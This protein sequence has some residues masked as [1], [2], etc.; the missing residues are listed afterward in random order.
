[1][2]FQRI[3]V[4]SCLLLCLVNIANFFH[5][6]PCQDRNTTSAMAVGRRCRK[7]CR[8]GDTRCKGAKVCR[9]DH[10]CGYSCIK[11][12]NF[13][14]YP[15]TLLNSTNITITRTN[16]S[17]IFQVE[18]PY[19]YNDRARYICDAG[20]ALV[21]DGNHMCHG[22]RGWT[23]TSLCARVEC[24]D[25]SGAIGMT[26]GYIS[27]WVE[28]P[29]YSGQQFTFE[30]P[31]GYRL[32]GSPVRSCQN[33]GRWS[34]VPNACDS[35]HRSGRCSHPGIPVNGELFWARRGRDP[36]SVGSI[37]TFRCTR[38]YILVGQAEQTCMYFLQWDGQ[39][40]PQ[41]VDS[42]YPDDPREAGRSIT[43]DNEDNEKC[44]QAGDIGSIKMKTRPGRDWAMARETAADK[45]WPWHALFT[46]RSDSN[47]YNSYAT[48]NFLGG[49]SLINNQWVLTAA[50]MF[51]LYDE[52]NDA[53]QRDFRITFGLYNR[54]ITRNHYRR[55]L[56]PTMVVYN[57]E[58]IIYS[59]NFDDVSVDYD[60]ALVK[61]GQQVKLNA[62]KTRWINVTNAFGWVNFTD[63]IRPVCLPC[64]PNNCLNS[65]LRN[66]GRIQ[67]NLNQ[68]Q[69]CDIETAAVLDVSNNQ[70]IAVVTGFGH[71]HEISINGN[72]VNAS[73]TLK[74]GVF[75]LVP[76]ARCLLFT[77]QWGSDLTERM[78]C[79]LSENGTVRQ[80]ACT[81]DGGGPLIRELYDENTR[82]SC[83][84]QIGIVSWG[85]GCGKKSIVN[86]V[87]SYRPGIYTKLPLF[88]SW[89][90]QTMEAN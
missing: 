22:R 28:G 62:A 43:A 50:H 81:G 44:G 40:A 65:Y 71:E 79:A 46:R 69:I 27:D 72:R 52:G 39:G 35:R 85:Y 12:D 10:E 83:W 26:N 31:S 11:L 77:N 6:G 76:H 5:I 58:R 25:P 59:S 3:L 57:T 56:D 53:W 41:C 84:I 61:L 80:H 38:G 90:N 18:A 7:W 78:I 37:I 33:N 75:K 64:M 73:V 68:Q 15:P 49:G 45:A 20:F 16:R 63:Y 48:R 8:P 13:C 67:G 32:I 89:L 87:N 14:P 17:G 19:L 60:I 9:C 1:M 29:Y 34:G 30:C 24:P 70:N 47:I 86:G 51:A 21:H 88:M 82:K 74:Q 23:G 66:K 54:P 42:K 36:F 2:P 4:L 55:R